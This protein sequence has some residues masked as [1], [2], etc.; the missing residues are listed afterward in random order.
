MIL[1]CMQ[2]PKLVKALDS[3]NIWTLNRYFDKYE[4]DP[5]RGRVFG[6]SNPRYA[7]QDFASNE[8]D[9][10]QK[11][12]NDFDFDPSEIKV[13]SVNWNPVIE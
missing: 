10:Y 3:K 11:L 8:H 7:F 6:L 4:I 2:A 1:Y 9:D 12:I 5:A 13:V